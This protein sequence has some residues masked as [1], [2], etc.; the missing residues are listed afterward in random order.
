MSAATK[1]HRKPKPAPTLGTVWLELLRAQRPLTYGEL[2][3]RLPELPHSMRA[4]A[5]QKAY[6]LGYLTRG[7]KFHHYTYYVTPAC[8]VPT[9]VP[10]AEVLEATTA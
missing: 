2:A 6:R 9:G 1:T 3:E 10:L 4:G 7:G 8:T 5:L